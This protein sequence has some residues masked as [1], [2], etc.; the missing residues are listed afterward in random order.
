MPDER[1]RFAE[2]LVGRAQ[3]ASDVLLASI[4][5]CAPVARQVVWPGEGCVN[6]CPCSDNP[7][8]TVW[9][10]TGVDEC[11][12]PRREFCL[13]RCRLVHVQSGGLRACAFAEVRGF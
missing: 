5:G 4:V 1:I 8:T 7:I 2:G 9:S 13:G 6:G 11:A 3:I 12:F 10:C